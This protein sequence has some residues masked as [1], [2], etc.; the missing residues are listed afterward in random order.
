MQLESMQ[1]HLI[2]IASHLIQGTLRSV[3]FA[4]QKGAAT[5][6]WN[7]GDDM[8]LGV[9]V[10]RGLE[11]KFPGDVLGDFVLTLTEDDEVEVYWSAE[12]S[13]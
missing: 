1:S 9:G 13:L 8:T 2:H 4:G 6:R 7:Q 5:L 11:K 12:V 10:V 3:A